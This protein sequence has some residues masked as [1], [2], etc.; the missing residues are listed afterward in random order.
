MFE[1]FCSFVS[2]GNYE[3][4]YEQ[5]KASI[6]STFNPWNLIPTILPELKEQQTTFAKSPFSNSTNNIYS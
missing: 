5:L 4:F 6:V 3:D 2:N 1:K